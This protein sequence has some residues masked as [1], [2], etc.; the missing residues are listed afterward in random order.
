MTKPRISSLPVITV[1][2]T[3]L[4]LTVASSISALGQSPNDVPIIDLGYA[5]Y[6]GV[7]DDV[8]NLTSYLGIRY[9]AAPIGDLRWRAPQAPASNDS[10]VQQANIGP[11]PCFQATSGNASTNPFV[12]RDL[13][14]TDSPEDC[15]FLNVFFPG[16]DV[17]TKPLPTLFWIHGGGY[18]EGGAFLAPGADL[19]RESDNEIVVVVV[20]YRLGLFGFL[21]GSEVK[22]NGDLNAGLLDQDFALRW[23]QE[24]ISKFGGDPAKVTI[25]ANLLHIVAHD[26][27][28]S[29]QLFRGAMTSSTYLPSQYLYNDTI[30]ELL[31]SG[32][33]EGSNP[34]V[35]GTFI[36]QR[37]TLSLEQRKLNG[38]A[39]LAVTNA[40]EG[41]IFVDQTN[42]I[43]NVTLYASSLFPELSSEL[44]QRIAELY[45]DL[46]TPLVQEE[47]ILGECNI[48]R[49]YSD[50]GFKTISVR[51]SSR[52]FLEIMVKTWDITFPGTPIVNNTDFLAA[53]QGGFLSFVV[54]QNPNDKI[55]PTTPPWD[56]YS[57]GRTE[58]V[59]NV[60]ASN[61]TDLHTVNTNEDLIERCN[62]WHSIGESIAQ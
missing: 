23:V 50:N 40:N 42:P 34:V 33:V 28:T 52:S 48:P 45:A 49:G 27:K 36:T 41:N 1:L 17:P 30:P 54:N 43:E 59:F 18:I 29:P 32:V 8:N 53:F 62:F 56:L 37:P 20:Q 14:A 31:Y 7:F 2:F 25:W 3:V 51:E 24:H 11:N 60:T 46:G 16:N 12:R 58:M 39:F 61:L 38:K 13:A 47:L 9:A 44:A 4:S 10:T 55:I 26:G 35:D 57:K 5:R 19:L 15:L 22:A 6:Q 21:A